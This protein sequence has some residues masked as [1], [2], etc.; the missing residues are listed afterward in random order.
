MGKALNIINILTDGLRLI[1]GMNRTEKSTLE[2]LKSG[3]AGEIIN[4]GTL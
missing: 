3:G 2:E 4:G 1:T